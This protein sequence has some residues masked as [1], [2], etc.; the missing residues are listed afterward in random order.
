MVA[1]SV[2]TVIQEQGTLDQGE[3]AGMDRTR[4][5]KIKTGPNELKKSTINVYPA[6]TGLSKLL[7]PISQTSRVAINRFDKAK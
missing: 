7:P 1:I 3:R 5:G 4:L 6:K 2:S